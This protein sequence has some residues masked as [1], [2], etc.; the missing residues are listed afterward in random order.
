MPPVDDVGY[1]A[2]AGLDRALGDIEEAGYWPVAP[3]SA[4][5]IT[6]T[7]AESASAETDSSSG[8]TVPIESA[9]ATSSASDALAG[10]VLHHGGLVGA[11]GLAA[12]GSRLGVAVAL[13]FARRCGGRVLPFRCR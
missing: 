7:W 6:T 5:M 9:R 2:L 13:Q 10:R 1:A 12:Q 4:P 11:A 8:C 3:E